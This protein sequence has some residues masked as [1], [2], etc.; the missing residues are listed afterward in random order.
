MLP[1]IAGSVQTMSDQWYQLPD[2]NKIVTHVHYSHRESRGP[3]VG[4]MYLL[5]IIVA[6]SLSRLWL[7]QQV[8]RS[9]QLLPC[10]LQSSFVHSL[11][12]IAHTL[13]N[14]DCQVT[15]F[16]TQHQF[17]RSQVGAYFFSLALSDLLQATGSLMN[18]KWVVIQASMGRRC[19]HLC[20]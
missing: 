10:S 2:G 1:P 14:W 13:L 16:N 18:A 19:R 6:H 15:G 12:S 3:L 7:W 5:A 11:A 20:R 4:G 9:F 17:I 8:Y